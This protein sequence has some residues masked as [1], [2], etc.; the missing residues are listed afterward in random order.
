MPMNIYRLKSIVQQYAW[1]SAVHIPEL[2]GQKNPD[3][4]PFAELWMGTHPK[5]QGEVIIPEGDKEIFTGSEQ[6]SGNIPADASASECAQQAIRLDSL[7]KHNPKQWGGLDSRGSGIK[8]LPFLF[9]VL[10]IE[11]PLSIQC[12][13]N[14][15]QA[16][17]GFERENKQGIPLDAF[18]RSYKDKNHKPEI[19][20]AVSPFT[21]MCGFRDLKTID[22]LFMKTG[23]HWYLMYLRP[24]VQDRGLPE[25][26]RCRKLVE[27]LLSLPENK[28]KL[29]VEEICG[30]IEKK[31]LMED[32]PAC[33][34]SL[35]MQLHRE[36]PQDIG[37]LA[38]LYLNVI[39][40]QPGEALYQPAGE[41]HAYIHGLGVELMANSDNVLRGGLT[42]KYIDTAELMEILYYKDS[43]KESLKAAPC[44]VK[45]GTL[46]S[47]VTPAKDFSLRR[48]SS[49]S[50]SVQGRRSIELAIVMTGEARF[51][52]LDEEKKRSM[53]KVFKKGESL[54]IP[55]DI[56]E[57]TCTCTGDVFFAAIPSDYA[58]ENPGTD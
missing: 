25:E 44:E 45:A 52:Y 22:D 51:S 32:D 11:K 46:Y 19:L 14:K 48:C 31:E 24:L 55:A 26:E 16:E 5:G 12:H 43:A 29:T 30:Y 7:L 27:R 47:Y 37:A 50:F 13:P 35:V 33:P 15:E 56:K 6:N 36:Y 42:E 38:P 10:A 3:K 49:S 8:D 1:G 17:K 41:L 40:L 39:H 2:I 54:V 4:A 53:E 58:A 18:N 28:A 57:Y 21:A 23:S 9:K 20:C 34:F